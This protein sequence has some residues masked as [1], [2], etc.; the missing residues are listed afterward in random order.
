MGITRPAETFTDAQRRIAVLGLTGA[1][2]FWGA[3][4]FLMK[5][6]SVAIA[7]HLPPGTGAWAETVFLML[8]FAVASI[9]FPLVFPAA[10]RG[11]WPAVKW[12]LVSSIPFTAGFLLQIYGLADVD[13]SIS[14]L[15]TSM[16]VV[17]T[18]FLMFML[19]RKAPG[20]NVAIGIAFAVGGLWLITGAKGAHFGRGEWLSLGCA[21][22]FSIHIV[23]TDFATRRAEPIAIAW[24]TSTFAAIGCAL[25]LLFVRPSPFP[26]IPAALHERAALV[27][28]AVTAILATVGAIALMNHFQ[29]RVSPNRAA[30]VYTLEPVFAGIFSWI[31]F[32]ESFGARKLIGGA[33]VVLGNLACGLRGEKKEEEMK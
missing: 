16:F 29:R 18:P 33:M 9:G 2:F 5:A 17:F 13:P 24:H 31:F 10:R 15:L 21:F 26:A 7:K 19:F 27:G 3:T 1:T 14:A 20:S 4:F 8:R 23:L 32:G 28:I 22:V 12:G 30:V 6:G 11:G 25:P